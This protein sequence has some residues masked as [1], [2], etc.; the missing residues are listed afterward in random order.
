LSTAHASVTKPTA[1]TFVSGSFTASYLDYDEH[2][3]HAILAKDPTATVFIEDSTFHNS[4]PLGA[5]A[6]PDVL[7]VMQAASF[8]VAYS[9]VSGAHCGFHFE[10]NGDK[11]EI[12]H[13]TVRGVTNGADVWGTSLASA[14][15]ITNSN[16]EQLDESLDETGTNGAFT[17]S[18]CYLTGTNN[19]ARLSSVTISGPA[20]A[21][22]ASAHPR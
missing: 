10:G 8:H 5:A 12:D 17:V 16:F 3:F 9:D 7:T 13:V 14:H 4:G 11:I 18:G 21:E 22:V 2:D 15:T 19:L 1:A 6:G 20:S